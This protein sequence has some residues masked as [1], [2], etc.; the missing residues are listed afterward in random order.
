MTNK[1]KVNKTLE[2]AGQESTS[3]NAVLAAYGRRCIVVCVL[4][5][6]NS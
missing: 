5:G 6:N 2:Q 1:N 3:D 4:D